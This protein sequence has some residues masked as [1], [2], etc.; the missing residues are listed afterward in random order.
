MSGDKENE[1][2]RMNTKH[3]TDAKLARL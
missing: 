1:W 2:D 3:P